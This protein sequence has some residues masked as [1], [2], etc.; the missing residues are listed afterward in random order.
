MLFSTGGNTERMRIDSSGN[1]GIGVTVPTSKLTLPLEE[2]S[3]FK[4]KFQAASGTG[5]AGLSTVDQSGAG[6][7]IGANSY[8]N[9]SGVPVYGRSDHPSSGIYFDGLMPCQMGVYVCV[10][11]Y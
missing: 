5:H 4:I 2:E 8:V 9:A 1:V 10:C 3:N 7:Y 6:L 11:M